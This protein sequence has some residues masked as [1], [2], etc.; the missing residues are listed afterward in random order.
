MRTGPGSGQTRVMT[1]AEIGSD[2]ARARE[3]FAQMQLGEYPEPI[4]DEFDLFSTIAG[5]VQWPMAWAGTGL[6]AKT[7][8]LCTVSALIATGKPQ[9]HSHIRGALAVGASREEIAD[10][11]THVA[12]YGGFPSAGTA[13]CLAQ[14]VFEQLDS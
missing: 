9:V 12:F 1:N 4:G 8:A 14:E 5:E 6:D 11:I 2:A 13:M 7:R 10:V 3:L